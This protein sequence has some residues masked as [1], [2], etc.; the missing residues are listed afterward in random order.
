MHAFLKK[1][2]YALAPVTGGLGKCAT[3]LTYHAVSDRGTHLS[4]PPAEFE[5]QIAYIA[6]HHK[7]VFLSELVERLKKGEDI[8][9]RVAIT[10]DD[11]YAD[12]YENVLPILE[13]YSVSV[14]IFLITDLIGK[15][16]M[17]SKSNRYSMLTE[18]QIKELRASG[19]VEFL[20]HSR[21][22]AVMSTLSDAQLPE[23]IEGARK[24]IER[25]LE[26]PVPKIFAYPKGRISDAARKYL[27]DNGYAA[28]S[29]RGGRVT[30][31]SDLLGLPRNDGNVSWNEF[32]AAFTPAADLAARLR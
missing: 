29:T 8:S 18:T 16:F 20:P 27:A 7:P 31:G 12:G 30:Q 1:S 15:T 5:K 19:L 10:L 28:V 24:E 11:G 2:F 6:K 32:R 3:I 23:E 26:G 25:V 17:D 14:S 13:K 21:S 22:H 9:S 4:I